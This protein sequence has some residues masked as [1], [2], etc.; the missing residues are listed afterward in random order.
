MPSVGRGVE[1]QKH[2]WGGGTGANTVEDSLALLSQCL[3]CDPAIPL[4]RKCILK[5]YMRTHP[6][7]HM[8]QCS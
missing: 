8:Q 6:R 3:P 2:Y 1:Q 4:P 7:R 5:K